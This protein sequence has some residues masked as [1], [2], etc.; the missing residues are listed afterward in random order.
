MSDNDY[1]LE[2]KDAKKSFGLTHALQGADLHIKK[3]EIVAIMGPSGS[4]KS[5]LLHCL[6]GIFKPDSGEV[7][8]DGRRLDAMSEEQRT[9]LRRTAFGFVFQFDN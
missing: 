2:I 9:K 5:T 3:G 8:F 4:G 7:L 6:A 1:I